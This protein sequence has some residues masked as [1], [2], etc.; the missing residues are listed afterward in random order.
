MLLHADPLFAAGAASFSS[1]LE[2]LSSAGLLE[3]GDELTAVMRSALAGRWNTFDRLFLVRGMR[4]T[5]QDE[6]GLLD[7]EIEVRTM[8][9]SA[10]A[11]SRRAGM[12]LLGAWSRLGSD[13]AA[14]QRARCV[15]LGGCHLPIAQAVVYSENGLTIEEAEA[16]SCWS[17]LSGY[18]GAA[19][20]LGAL[21]H[22]VTQ[23]ALIRVRP[24]A[25]A[26][27]A[28]PSEVG[29]EPMTWTPTA[30]IA[31]ERHSHAAMRLFAS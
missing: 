16:L 31:V 12:S 11:A 5:T 30:D 9:A 13:A 3:T 27:L 4:A 19:V 20:R 25:D 29:T 14:A 6:L 18:A 26:L 1:G 7:D 21:G 8:G 28:K 23:S 10:R 15:T 17:L 22:T 24:F 2:A